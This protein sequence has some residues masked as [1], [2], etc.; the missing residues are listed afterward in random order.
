MTFSVIDE[1]VAAK[2]NTCEE[3]VV[4]NFGG[5]LASLR[6]SGKS[7]I[8]DCVQ[9]HFLHTLTQA[10]AH[11]HAAKISCTSTD[12]IA[13]VYQLGMDGQVELLW[14]LQNP[15]EKSLW[16]LSKFG[17]YAGEW[18]LLVPVLQHHR[19][20]IWD[21]AEGRLH[22]ILDGPNE[23]CLDIAVHTKSPFHRSG[24]QSSRSCTQS[25]PLGM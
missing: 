11:P 18:L 17:G 12:K 15:V 9:F 22:R 24:T 2:N 14:R 3:R 10:S 8:G 25:A 19:I 21:L 16:K 7:L 20:Y 13:R 23:P 4:V 5:K 1:A 6:V